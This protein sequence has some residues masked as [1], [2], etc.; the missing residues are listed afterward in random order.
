[1]G[2]REGRERKKE[3]EGK[4]EKERER[5]KGREGKRERGEVRGEGH[6]VKMPQHRKESHY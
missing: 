2:R 3:R 6:C 4:G 5:R 1:M